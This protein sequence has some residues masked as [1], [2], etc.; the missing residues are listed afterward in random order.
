M[1]KNE[2]RPSRYGALNMFM[3]QS[4]DAAGVLT[5]ELKMKAESSIGSVLQTPVI[6]FDKGITIGNTRSVTI[7]DSENTSQMFT[8]NFATYSWGFTVVPAMFMNNEISIQKDFEKKFNKY[9]YKFGETLDSACVSALSANK[10]QVFND[11]LMYSQAG[12][13]V[14]APFLMADNIIGDINPMMAANDHFGQIHICGNAGVESL[15]RKLAQKDLYNSENKTLEYSDKVLHF[16]TRI[17]NDSADYAGFYAVQ[18]GSLGLL[19][20]FEREA[21]LG[22]KMA[23]GTEWGIDTLPM[24]NFPIGTYYYESKGDFSAIAG[25]A[26]ADMT[27]ARKEHYGF[28]VDIAIITPYNS[29]PTAIASPIMQVAIQKGSVGAPVVVTN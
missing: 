26:T 6:D 9:L 20:R 7:A 19:T 28:A 14:K 21:L 18:E 2:L 16:S 1:D 15:V 24:L 17:P 13:V 23:D 5:D 10:T 22:T 27:R 29:D 11:L 12:N 25:A 4:E 3:L 8:I